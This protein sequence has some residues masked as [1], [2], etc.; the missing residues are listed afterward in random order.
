MRWVKRIGEEGV[1]TLLALTIEAAHTA[2]LIKR[3]SVYRVIVV[4]TLLRKLPEPIQAKA[5][6]WMLRVQCI[7]TQKSKYKNKLYAVHAPE[8]EC[9]NKGKTRTP[10]EFGVKVSIATTLKQGLL[11]GMRSMPGNPY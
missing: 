11:V 1:E 10:Y 5:Q 2:G 8:V 4:A 3:Y 9:I 6:D 7:L